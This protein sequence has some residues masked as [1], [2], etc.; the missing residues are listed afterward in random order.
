MCRFHRSFLISYFQV[1]RGGSRIFFRRGCTRL[2]LYFNT[3]KPHDFFFFA[4]YQLY[5]KTAGHLRG[6][7]GFAPLHPPPR[8][9][10]ELVL[11]L[12]LYLHK[13]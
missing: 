6:G 5:E 7:E 1:S 11:K 12:K 13:C 9:A 3:N 10:P 2:L 4:E 8:S